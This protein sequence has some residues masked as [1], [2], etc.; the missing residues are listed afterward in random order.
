MAFQASCQRNYS[1]LKQWVL[2]VSLNPPCP[3]IE[4]SCLKLPCFLYNIDLILRNFK[5]P[6]RGKAR[7]A[8]TLLPVK[9]S[10]L[11][12]LHGNKINNSMN[13]LLTFYKGG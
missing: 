2:P 12:G 8:S 9:I 10:I 11:F 13:F 1:A 6:C 3:I 5:Q 4:L 7:L